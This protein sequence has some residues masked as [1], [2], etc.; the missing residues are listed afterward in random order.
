M[1]L[2]PFLK[3]LVNVTIHQVHDVRPILHQNLINYK[4]TNL[5]IQNTKGNWCKSPLKT[6][7]EKAED[8]H[9]KLILTQR[10][11]RLMSNDCFH[12]SKIQNNDST[13][14]LGTRIEQYVEKNYLDST[15]LISKIAK[16][17][18]NLNQIDQRINKIKKELQMNVAILDQNERKNLNRSK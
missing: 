10:I 12:F 7:Q 11:P 17:I 4:K 18:Q 2:I 13:R 5:E 8:M 16:T 14:K 15:P 1:N 3:S 6:S 9:D